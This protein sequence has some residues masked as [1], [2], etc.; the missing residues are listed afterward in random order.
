MPSAAS[1][2]ASKRVLIVEDEYLVAQ[3]IEEFLE[4]CGCSVIG[5]C[6]SVASALVAVE[7]DTFDLAVLDVNLRGEKVYPVAELLAERHIP[8]LFLSGYGEEAVPPDHSDWKVC[9]K[10]FRSKELIAMLE[11]ELA[12]GVH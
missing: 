12:A 4:D 11:A 6:G 8:F 1:L 10:P 2:L 3:L 5:P 9:S 7:T